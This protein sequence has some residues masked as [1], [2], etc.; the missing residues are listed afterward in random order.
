VYYRTSASNGV[1]QLNA[2]THLLIGEF[3]IQIIKS[4]APWN[5]NCYL[6]RHLPTG[7]Q[8][9]IDPGADA[10]TIIETVLANGSEL[11]QLWLTHSHHDHIGAA[12]RLSQRFGLSC[13]LHKADQRILRHAPMY[14][15]RFAGL[16]I[17][18]PTEVLLFDTPCQFQ[19]GGCRVDVIHTPGH[20][21]GGVV[22]VLEGFI[23]TGDILIYEHLGRTDLP[24][25]DDTLI[26]ASVNLLLEN[27]PAETILFGGHGRPW[28]A[29]MARKW[30]QSVCYDPPRLDYFEKHAKE[31]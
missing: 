25:G 16:Q 18:V 15:L 3:E 21:P 12:A 20:T 6:V 22:Y 30:W 4:G 31:S 11:A 29:A 19:L 26:K 10:E 2:E 1:S 7:E 9:I 27:L 13:H 24:G 5:E 14:A 28:T 23:F 8:A 17:E